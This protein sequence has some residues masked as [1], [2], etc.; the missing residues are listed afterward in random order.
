M[1]GRTRGNWRL[2]TSVLA[3]A[4]LLQ[5]T[6]LMVACGG[7]VRREDEEGEPEGD[8][9]TSVPTSSPNSGGGSGS[10]GVSGPGG[11]E[12]DLPE[13]KLGV[14]QGDAERCIFLYEGRCYEDKLDA[15]GCACKKQ[16]GTT[17]S[18]GFPSEDKPTQVTCR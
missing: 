1:G 17:C 8:D 14:K 5:V 2:K 12:V 13:C 9:P 18:S 16:R 6:T 10:G 3:I 4:A 11:P 15:C 7:T